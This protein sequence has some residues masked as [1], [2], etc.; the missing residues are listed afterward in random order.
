[1][2][3]TL[4][5]HR[6][7]GELRALEIDGEPWFVGKDVAG[8]LGYS[9]TDGAIR[10]HVDAEDKLTR[11]IDGS[12]QMRDMS[13]INES[14]LYSLIFSSKLSSAKRFKRWVTHEV[15]PSIRRDGAYVVAK[16]DETEEEV[17]AKGLLAAARALERKDRR[18][19]ELEPKAQRYDAL[20]DCG[21]VLSTT[22]I[23]K[24]Y[25]YSAIAFNKLLKGYGVQ[26]K[27]N[28]TWVLTQRYA[29]LGYVE[30][31]SFKV[32]HKS[33]R[34]DIRNNMYWTPAGREF[35]HDFLADRGIYPLS[36]QKLLEVEA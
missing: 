17:L 24:D 27:V 6:E 4:Y 20:T 14:G 2:E 1:M 15:L 26:W 21:G 18:I 31:K 10:K 28:N 32:P 12:G 7:F 23:A 3:V 9:D 8:S 5:E 19:A 16:E 13:I 22:E 35:L 36:E 29:P 33:G 34:E 25:G 30:F 11:Q